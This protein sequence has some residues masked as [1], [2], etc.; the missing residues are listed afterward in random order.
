M[1]VLQET[2]ESANKTFISHVFSTTEEDKGELLNVV[3]YS[4]MGVVPVV[5]MNKLI[6]LL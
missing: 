3:Q 4:I 2:K 1:D 5:I 6:Q